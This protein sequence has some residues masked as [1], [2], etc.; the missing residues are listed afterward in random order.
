MAGPLA[1]PPD[2]A[3]RLPSTPHTGNGRITVRHR[4]ADGGS[5]PPSSTLG[6]H[7][8][9]PGLTGYEV[10]GRAGLPGLESMARSEPAR[11][12]SVS[13][14]SHIFTTD[15]WNMAATF[16]VTGESDDDTQDESVAVSHSIT[17][18]G[19]EYENVP[20][21]TVRVEVTD[22][23]T[24]PMQRSAIELPG[25]PTEMTLSSS[26]LGEVTVS[27]QP[28]TAGGDPVRY[29]VHLRPQGG[30]GKGKTKTPKAKK[31]AVT[32]SGLTPG[33]TYRVWV[34]ARNEAG[35]GE[36]VHATITLPLP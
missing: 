23:T 31:T 24:P 25:P 1:G 6:A 20:V 22:T 34:R 11:P 9:T 30:S 4:P 17:R 16:T 33:E 3:T 7:S 21:S 5:I 32:Y 10:R 27:W 13:P 12:C 35:K 19:A 36:R 15:N 29:I 2:P 28:P 8:A 26:A 14:A 18:A